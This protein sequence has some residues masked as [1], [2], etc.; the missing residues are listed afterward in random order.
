MSVI[1]S[2]ALGLVMVKT[3]SGVEAYERNRPFN[4]AV[5]ESEFQEIFEFN[6]LTC[7]DS[8][9]KADCM[10]YLGWDEKSNQD[11]VDMLRRSTQKIRDLLSEKKK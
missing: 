10:A 11:N 9:K 6:Y 1:A 4:G 7:S 8:Y 5:S 3:P 2:L